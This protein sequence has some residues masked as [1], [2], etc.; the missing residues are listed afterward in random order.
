M[1]Y[2][3]QRKQR[4]Y[5][6]YNSANV[7]AAWMLLISSLYADER[8]VQ[9]T[10]GIAHLEPRAT[11]FSD[12]D[13]YTPSIMMCHIYHAWQNLIVASTPELVEHNEPFRYDL[14]N[15]GR[16][17]LAQLSSPMAQ[18]FVNATKQNPLNPQEVQ[19][20]GTM[21]IELLQDTDKLVSTDQA[22]LLGPWIQSAREWGATAAN[23]C[24]SVEL[25]STNCA[26]FYEWNARTQITTWNPTQVD[27]PKIPGGP[28]DYAA[29]HWNG[30]IK[31]YYAVR[32]QLLLDQALKDQ[33]ANQPLNQTE[34]DRIFAQHAY[35]WTTATTPYPTERTG[36]ALTVTKD[37]FLKYKHWF[38]LCGEE[39]TTIT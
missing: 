22:F 23:D 25:N 31:D 26:N 37:L 6:L 38:A 11:L 10:T 27:S 2:M 39:P 7:A 30:L 5:G 9:D 34:V 18:N 19:R 12:D 16:E 13:Q 20:T 28:I 29:K 24:Y 32:A 35:K 14:V 36:N 4:Q 33:R 3:S 8:S 15:L 1:S 17:V 21:Y